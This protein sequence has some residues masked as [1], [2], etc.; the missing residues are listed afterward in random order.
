VTSDG[1]FAPV[2]GS[3][4]ACAPC[5]TVHGVRCLL[6]GEHAGDGTAD[7]LLKPVSA[8]AG[9]DD[10]DEVRPSPVGDAR[11]TWPMPVRGSARGPF[12]P[13]AHLAAEGPRS[14][15]ATWLHAICYV[16]HGVRMVCRVS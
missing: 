12:A 2:V 16:L 4:T 11:R 14:H 9:Y 8:G 5:C 1:D 3:F 6:S 15:G 7:E 13:L 10:K